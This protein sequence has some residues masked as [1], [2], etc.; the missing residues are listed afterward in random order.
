L[1]NFLSHFSAPVISALIVVIIVLV[2]IPELIR[3]RQFENSEYHHLTRKNYRTV[4]H[5][6]GTFGEYLTFRE[7]NKI[8]GYKKFLFNL[9]ISKSDGETSEIDT[10]FLHESGIYVIESKNYS[11]WIFGNENDT[12]W[13]QVLAGGRHRNHFYN[14]I[15]QNNTHIS[16]LS[17]QLPKLDEDIYHSVIAFSQRCTLKSITLKNP[18]HI[19]TKRDELIRSLTPAIQNN[20]LTPQQIDELYAILLPNTNVSD[21]VKLEH[22]AQIHQH[23][24]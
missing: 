17:R 3:Y 18:L 11:G 13:T 5:D 8:Q 16:C 21:E 7:L 24:R 15:R 14:P 20:V 19:V 1:I 6:V 12:R 9:Y 2:L 23:V 22:I 10:V 4:T